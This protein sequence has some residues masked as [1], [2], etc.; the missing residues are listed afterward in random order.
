MGLLNI[1]HTYS[2]VHLKLQEIGKVGLGPAD[3]VEFIQAFP[4]QDPIK[5]P[6]HLTVEHPFYLKFL[7]QPY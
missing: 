4:F 5:E 7:V 1:V 3:A 6:L 2:L